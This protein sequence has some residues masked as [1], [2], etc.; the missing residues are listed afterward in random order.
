MGKGNYHFI[1]TGPENAWATGKFDPRKYYNSEIGRA[2]AEM[3]RIY[4]EHKF[5]QLHPD[6]LRYWEERGVKKEVFDIDKEAEQM[7]YSVLTPL[8]PEPGKQYPLVYC[9]HGGGENIF[10]AEVYGYGLLTGYDQC[11]TVCPTASTHGNPMVESEFLR[12]LKFLEDNAYPVDF[13]R[14]YVVGFS[15]GEGA[16]QRLAMLFPNRIAGIGPTPGPN[17]FRGVSLPVLQE[18]YAEKFGLDMP[19]ICI[20]G[21]LDGGDMWPLNT[22]QCVSSYN[23][24]MEK[25][26]K[27]KDFEPLTLQKTY[28]IA[29]DDEDTVQRLFG[30]KFDA[31]WIQP[32]YDTFLYMAESYNGAG[33][34]M[35]RFGCFL[36]M[37]HTQCPMQAELIWSYLSQF[38][39]NL[40]TGELIFT[41]TAVGGANK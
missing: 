10:S 2:T 22:D 36:G 21:D 11:I 31:T 20:G 37:P 35:A 14:V 29:A 7:M 25:V 41:K 34:P 30:M 24:Y 19:I 27:L 40:E 12:I 9:L 38:S 32:V 18:E 4:D 28:E 6:V 17:S 39:R 1:A 33:V 23:F 16:A 26:A 3:R 13:S 5:E 8:E 15:G